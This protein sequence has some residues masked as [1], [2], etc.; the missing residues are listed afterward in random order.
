M[1]VNGKSSGQISIEDRGLL[2]GDGLFETILCEDGEPMLFAGHMQRLQSG[3][4]TLGISKPDSQLLLAEL[5]QVALQESCVVK[6]II[7]RGVS[8][9]GY[10]YD[11]NEESCTR[12]IYRSDLPS[13]PLS[14]YAN[15]IRLY[16]CQ[17]RLPENGKLAGIKHLN[18]LDQIVARS[19]WTQGFEEGIT[20]SA[21]DNIIE[22]TMSNIFI[23]LNGKWLTPRLDLCGVKGVMREFILHNADKLSIQCEEANIT[24]AQVKSA[25]AIFV[26]NSVIGIWPVVDF[27]SQHYAIGEPTTRMMQ[28]LHS[29]VS[30]LYKKS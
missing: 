1:L 6:I 17:H 10:Q 25:D 29:N 28:Y 2:Y 9:R 12:I 24:L 20:L 18:R 4:K 26:C 27:E 30:S 11:A 13:I 21:T 15:G 3:C 5:Q 19:E 22:G 16:L 7:T 23:A 14:H 8:A